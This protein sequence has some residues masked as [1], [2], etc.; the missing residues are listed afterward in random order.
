LPFV[1]IM[2]PLIWSF[3]CTHAQCSLKLATS[4]WQFFKFFAVEMQLRFNMRSGS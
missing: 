1:E 4:W 2:I 3:I